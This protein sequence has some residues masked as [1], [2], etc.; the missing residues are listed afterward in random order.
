MKVM[1]AVYIFAYCITIDLR[2]DER[3]SPV[4]MH[5]IGRSP[6]TVSESET[7]VVLIDL[8][9]RKGTVVKKDKDGNW[10]LLPNR[11]YQRYEPAIKKIV[12]DI[13]GKT[14]K[15]AV[16]PSFLL[17]FSEIPGEWVGGTSDQ[18]FVYEG[19]PKK[20]WD[21]WKEIKRKDGTGRYMFWNFTDPPG[22]SVHY[23]SPQ[24]PG[25]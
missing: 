17:P 7:K 15:F 3:Q 25:F 13:T 6:R 21:A 9:K 14:G 11:L 5:E 19:P 8:E 18:A 2:A 10:N 20:G 22:E 12:F 16:P 1:L 24:T 23:Y 4:S